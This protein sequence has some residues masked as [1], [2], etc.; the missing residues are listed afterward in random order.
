MELDQAGRSRLIRPATKPP[1]TL[2][3]TATL[4]NPTWLQENRIAEGSKLRWEPLQG[5]IALRHAV[6]GAS[7]ETKLVGNPLLDS[8][9]LGPTRSG[10]FGPNG[11]GLIVP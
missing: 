11:R 2:K 9:G 3:K 5:E 10:T 8:L 6:R 4:T 1:S 7:L